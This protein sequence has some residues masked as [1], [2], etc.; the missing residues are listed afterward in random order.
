MTMDN[1]PTYFRG[2]YII[3]VRTRARRST[4]AAAQD[5][6]TLVVALDAQGT[7]R[8]DLYLDDGHSF[9]YRRG[10]YAH[11]EF[12]FSEGV[13]TAAA[14]PEDVPGQKFSSSLL[15]ERIIILGARGSSKGWHAEDVKEQRS[16]A[17]S[18]GPLWLAPGVPSAAVVVRRPELPVTG[19]WQI[20]ISG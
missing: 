14:F 12:T 13:L 17:V 11:R 20:R 2:G 9:A 10:V 4:T 5:P 8:G 1:I 7:A 3:P 16:L 19:D 15:I 6:I 18:E